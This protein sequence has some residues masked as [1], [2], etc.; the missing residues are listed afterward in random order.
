MTAQKQTELDLHQLLAASISLG[1][2]DQH[3]EGV[4]Q[5]LPETR[6]LAPGLADIQIASVSRL[7]QHDRFPRSHDWEN[8]LPLLREGE[9]LLWIVRKERSRFRFYFG[10]KSNMLVVSRWEAVREQRHHFQALSNHFCRRAFPESSLKEL[11]AAEAD[12]LLWDIHQIDLGGMVV[13]SGAPSPKNLEHERRFEERD[14]EQRPSASLNDPLEAFLDEKDLCLVFSICRATASELK[15]QMQFLTGA[16]SILHPHIATERTINVGTQVGA[17][18]D[19][20]NATNEGQGQQEQRDI[21]A[22]MVQ[23]FKGAK[24]ADEKERKTKDRMHAAVNYQFSTT[25]TKSS[26]TNWSEQHG[27]S[28]TLHELH[29]GLELLDESLKLS[30]DHLLNAVGTGAYFGGVSVY[31]KDQSTTLRIGRALA[32]SLAGSHSHVRPFQVIPYSGN[33]AHFALRHNLALKDVLS[34]IALLN[35]QQAGLLLMLPDTEL[36]GLKLKRNVFYGRAPDRE[37]PST[38]PSKEVYLGCSSFHTPTLAPNGSMATS[39]E[40]GAIYVPPEDLLS[41]VL[42][43]GTTGSGKTVR[44]VDLLNRLDP[45]LFRILVIETAKKCFRDYLHRPAQGLP[46]VFC[47]GGREHEP[48]RINPFFFDPGSNPKRHI[49]ILSDALSDLLPTEALIAPKLREAILSCYLRRGLDLETGEFRTPGPPSYP[50]MLDFNAEISAL[51]TEL[52]YS[53]EINENYRGALLGRSRIFIDDLYQDLFAHGGNRTFDEL[54]DR[55]VIIELDELP[56]SEINMPAFVISVLLERLRAHCARR[57]LGREKAPIPYFLVVI[58]EA[59]N[60]LSRRIEETADPRQTGGGK[61]LLQQ[62]VRLLQEGRDLGIGVMVVDQSPQSLANAVLKNTNTKLVHRLVDG[63]ELRI[64]GTTLGLDEKEWPDLGR[65][66]DGEC[67]VSMKNGG[68]PLKLAPGMMAKQL[69]IHAPT[70][71]APGY[72]QAQQLLRSMSE[73]TRLAELLPLAKQLLKAAGDSHEILVYMLGKHLAWGSVLTRDFTPP[74][75]PAEL[76]LYLARQLGP[77]LS[78]DREADA[79]LLKTLARSAAAPELEKLASEVFGVGWLLSVMD[80][81]VA[82]LAEKLMQRYGDE[83]QVR[84]ITTRITAW[85]EAHTAG[86]DRQ[87]DRLR[88]V[89]ADQDALGVFCATI[90]SRHWQREKPPSGTLRALGSGAR[91]RHWP[92]VADALGHL[93]PATGWPLLDTAMQS[94]ALSLVLG[95]PENAAF[96]SGIDSFITG[97]QQWNLSRK[98]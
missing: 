45:A 75:T 97:Y 71:Q 11:D 49:S 59:H 46:R 39:S 29:A 55:D 60:V 16:R 89:L 57:R 9:E 27:M 12:K 67:V 41:H 10:L 25:T 42:I 93:V 37:R 24:K 84:D 58:E 61:H 28:Q 18:R 26:G 8:L 22:K 74:R 81:F 30:I 77:T 14:A 17:H 78:P 13:V 50:T 48:F 35:T 19:E 70:S 66:E 34:G 31:A 83:A 6:L 47:L 40:E 62:I 7:G 76:P 54:F 87:D 4:L 23:F 85:A 86:S 15:A 92:Y 68:K 73:V 38:K 63:E 51:C 91:A 56:P 69:Q 5:E 20:S 52:R 90:V 36:P 96:L 95:H 32:G 80:S 79:L 2:P 44:T 94:A 3:I 64:I 88:V 82:D 72:A 98:E 21:L 1:L 43:T 53:S 65:L 33:E